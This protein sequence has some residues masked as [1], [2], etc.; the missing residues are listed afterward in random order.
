MNSNFD[1]ILIDSYK[2]RRF[3]KN[4]YS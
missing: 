1:A 3:Y 4:Q 2:Y